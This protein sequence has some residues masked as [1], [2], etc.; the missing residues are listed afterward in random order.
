M[1][2]STKQ[3][4]LLFLFFGLEGFWGQ[5]LGPNFPSP[6]ATMLALRLDCSTAALTTPQ[7]VLP[8]L[9]LVEL[10]MLDFSDCTAKSAF[11]FVFVP[12]LQD[13]FYGKSSFPVSKFE[14]WEFIGNYIFFQKN[15]F[16]PCSQ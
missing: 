11:S 1:H 5:P 9:K 16:P 8:I 10:Q 12:N 13:N 6:G 3:L 7:K 14:D 4:R 2:A 15:V